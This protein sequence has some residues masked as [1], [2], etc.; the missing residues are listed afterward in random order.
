[1]DNVLRM[2]QGRVPRQLALLITQRGL[3]APNALADA[4]WAYGNL[5][6][7]VNCVPNQEAE[8]GLWGLLW[9]GHQGVVAQALWCLDTVLIR[10]KRLASPPPGEALARLR[11]I[12]LTTPR[13]ECTRHG[14]RL[15]TQLLKLQPDPSTVDCFSRPLISL[16]LSPSANLQA[17]LY[18][19]LRYFLMLEPTPPALV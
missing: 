6:C 2:N 4:I 9:E 12:L 16:T 5:Q 14:L 1:M 10:D 8:A 18:R 3:L 7:G 17:D 13:G 19:A 15:L 11:A